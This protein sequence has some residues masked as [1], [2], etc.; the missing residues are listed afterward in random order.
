MGLNKSHTSQSGLAQKLASRRGNRSKTAKTSTSRASTPLLQAE[1][2]R[3]ICATATS[4]PVSQ[5]VNEEFVAYGQP[6]QNI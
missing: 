4:N 3:Q 1:G 2:L 6:S 5:H